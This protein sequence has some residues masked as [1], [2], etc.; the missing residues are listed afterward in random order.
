MKEDI[1]TAMV[2]ALELAKRQR[3]IDQL[4]QQN[5]FLIDTFATRDARQRAIIELQAQT[6]QRQEL[7]LAWYQGAYAGP[8]GQKV[9]Q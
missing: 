1:D 2:A 4:E 5:Q 3:R 9:I 6:I 7:T 8:E